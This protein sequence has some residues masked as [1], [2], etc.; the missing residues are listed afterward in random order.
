MFVLW[1]KKAIF[2]L[3]LT[4]LGAVVWMFGHSFIPTQ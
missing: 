2:V 4:A 3:M 1:L